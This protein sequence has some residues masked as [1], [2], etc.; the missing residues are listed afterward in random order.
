MTINQKIKNA[1][2]TVYL[3]TDAQPRFV[4]LVSSG[5]NQTPFKSLKSAQ[6][7]ETEEMTVKVSKI[8]FNNAVF[9]SVED[10]QAW[11]TTKGFEAPAAEVFK[12]LDD[13]YVVDMSQGIEGK[14]VKAVDDGSVMYFM[15]DEETGEEVAKTAEEAPADTTNEAEPEEKAQKAADDFIAAVATKSAD[16]LE[17]LYEETIDAI[18]ANVPAEKMKEFVKPV[19]KAYAEFHKAMKQEDT[20]TTTTEETAA[21]TAV[22]TEEAPAVETKTEETVAKTEEETSAETPVEADPATKSPEEAPAVLDADTVA[23]MVAD[24]VAAAL[25]PVL[26]KVEETEAANTALTEKVSKMESVEQTRKSAT[27]DYA[28][29]ET[30]AKKNDT[31]PAARRFG[32]DTAGIR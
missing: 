11:M 5:A 32:N 7:L 30:V 9:K 21:E 16:E 29:R 6:P 12:A 13:M 20:V 15:A 17:A 24:A 14:A 18:T 3:L 31:S 27:D 10:C 22:T 8:T 25:E 26:K 19:L 28:N 1:R 23:K 2:K 4:S